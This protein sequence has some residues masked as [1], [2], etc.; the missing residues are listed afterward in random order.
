MA[1]WLEKA[2][3]T[4]SDVTIITKRYLSRKEKKFSEICSTRVRR[5]TDGPDGSQMA[6]EGQTGGSRLAL[7]E[8]LRRLSD[9]SKMARINQRWHSHCSQMVL[10]LLADGSQMVLMSFSDSSQM[11]LG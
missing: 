8:S 4:D 11:A 2:T 10:T 7:T 6:L 5:C 9:E 1:S 3:T